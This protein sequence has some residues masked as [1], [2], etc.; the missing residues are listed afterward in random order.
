MKESNY[1]KV[2]YSKTSANQKH[3]YIYLESSIFIHQ[4]LSSQ[5]TQVKLGYELMGRRFGLNVLPLFFFGDFEG[6]LHGSAAHIENAHRPLPHQILGWWVLDHGQRVVA[7]R[8]VLEF[9]QS[10]VGW[11]KGRKYEIQDGFWL[12]HC[13]ETGEMN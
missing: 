4:S 10:V 3:N 1:R 8:D 9:T 5:I 6:D 12:R 2:K 7:I 13:S 11:E